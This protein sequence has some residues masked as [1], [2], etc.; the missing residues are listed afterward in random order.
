MGDVVEAARHGGRCGGDIGKTRRVQG[1]SRLIRAGED[2]INVSPT[3]DDA[4]DLSDIIPGDAIENDVRICCDRTNP[5]PDLITRSTSI[6][7]ILEQLTRF[8]DPANNIVRCVASGDARIVVPDIRNRRG[9]RATKRAVA[10][11][12][13]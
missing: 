3:V 6:R 7:V 12:R 11:G 8:A 2:F 9:L 10:Y 4:N 1:I 5:W 13:S